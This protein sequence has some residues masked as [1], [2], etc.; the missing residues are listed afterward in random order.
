MTNKQ[1][2]IDDDDDEGI[3]E[4]RNYYSNEILDQADDNCDLN[5]TQER[6]ISLI[7]SETVGQS[8]VG[9]FMANRSVSIDQQDSILQLMNQSMAENSR[10]G[11]DSSNFKIRLNPMKDVYLSQT[12]N[13]RINKNSFVNDCT[14]S[15]FLYL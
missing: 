15:S 1:E 12:R 5:G 14:M 4:G 13:R 11:G 2:N 7:N 3:I 6:P 9:G 8:F 10:T